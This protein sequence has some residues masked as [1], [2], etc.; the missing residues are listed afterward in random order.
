MPVSPPAPVYLSLTSAA[1][2]FDVDRKTIRRAIDRG[3]L[4][5]VRL[6]ARGDLRVRVVDLDRW[7]RPVRNGAESTESAG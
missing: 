3:E 4:P 7:A 2:R 6:G 1:V 5:A